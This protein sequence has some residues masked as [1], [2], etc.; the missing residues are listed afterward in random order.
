MRK[1]LG[2]VFVAGA[3]FIGYTINLKGALEQNNPLLV[4][5]GY[6]VVGIGFLVTLIRLIRNI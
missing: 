2:L 3:A 1:N 4:L 5:A 6:A